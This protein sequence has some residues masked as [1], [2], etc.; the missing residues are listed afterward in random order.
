MR[1]LEQRLF[2]KRGTGYKG[3]H[4]LLLYFIFF[5][6]T[7]ES[8]KKSCFEAG[9]TQDNKRYLPYN[10]F[11]F[12]H[13]SSTTC[14]HQGFKALKSKLWGEQ[15]DCWNSS[16]HVE[17]HLKITAVRTQERKMQPSTQAAGKLGLGHFAF[18]SVVLTLCTPEMVFIEKILCELFLKNENTQITSK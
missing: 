7:L 12:L 5:S 3:L 15:K 1:T 13:L 18:T 6:D 2:W 16:G 10:S 8:L 4:G 9:G 17:A 11:Y 14:M